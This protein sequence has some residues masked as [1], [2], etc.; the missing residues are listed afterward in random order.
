MRKHD[1]SSSFQFVLD[2]LGCGRL[3]VKDLLRDGDSPWEKTVL[4]E[5]VA[6]GEIVL[7]ITLTL[8]KSAL[9]LE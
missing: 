6:S 3:S 8:S 9:L 2:F 4:L 5:N 7:N 1:S